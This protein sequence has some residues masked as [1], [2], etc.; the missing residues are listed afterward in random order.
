MSAS[1]ENEQEYD[2]QSR[3]Q[4]LKYRS[5][6]AVP[7]VR[8]DSNILDNSPTI[9]QTTT[10]P[11][12]NHHDNLSTID[13]GIYNQLKQHDSKHIA[14]FSSAEDIFYEAS[15]TLR[16]LEPLQ[17]Q[18]PP[19]TVDDSRYFPSLLEETNYPTISVIMEPHMTKPLQK[20]YD[21]DLQISTDPMMIPNTG[22][23]YND[24]DEESF[25]DNEVSALLRIIEYEIKLENET[26]E[27][28]SWPSKVGSWFKG[29]FTR[30]DYEKEYPWTTFITRSESPPS[31]LKQDDVHLDEI[32]Q[33]IYNSY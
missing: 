8:I 24:R 1:N 4:S 32:F 11:P 6:P 13:L 21:L 14:S 20:G 5:R 16:D 27:S 15:P 12:R 31:E 28:I 25:E 3:T 23:F 26:I 10:Y 33:N 22:P 29:M 9:V 2:N 17:L 30:T 7:L 18:P 19:P